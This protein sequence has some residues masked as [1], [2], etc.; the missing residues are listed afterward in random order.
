MVS[1]SNA[2][3]SHLVILW[4]LDEHWK[5][6]SLREK[7][8]KV[9]DADDLAAKALQP[10]ISELTADDGWNSAENSINTL[11][12]DLRNALR[13][14]IKL[15]EQKHRLCFD[16]QLGPFGS[17]AFS[18]DGK[19]LI[20][21]SKNET[22]QD[23]LREAGSLPCVNL[24]NT[25][26]MSLRQQLLGHQDVIMW[27]AMSPDDMLVASVSWD[28][29][30]RRSGACR[31]ILGPFGGQLWSGAFSPDG[32]YLAISQG[33]PKTYVHIYEIESEQPVSR[34]EGFHHRA[35]SFA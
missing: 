29:T 6:A 11:A 21:L 3:N 28:G 34:F 4:G 22:T 12:Q 20:Y 13:N 32:K 33:N 16:G 1:E 30:A 35:L 14:A 19:T 5:L 2:D 23:G 7:G 18:P 9:V 24:W 10:L 8:E 27:A 17:P 15:H 31:H 25:L 26:S